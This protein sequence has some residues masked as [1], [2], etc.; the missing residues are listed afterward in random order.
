MSNSERPPRARPDDAE[1]YPY[2]LTNQIG[3]GSFATVYRGYHVVRELFVT[4]W[5]GLNAKNVLTK[6]FPTALYFF[7]QKNRRAVAVKAVKTAILKA[8]LLDNL[9]SEIAILKSL[10]HRH[11]TSLIDI[12][13]CF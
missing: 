12:V 8:K 9:E 3:E 5:L 6:V 7:L 10:N 2:V 4:G 11:I 1:A 13:V